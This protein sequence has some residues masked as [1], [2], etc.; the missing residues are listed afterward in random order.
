MWAPGELGRSESRG[1]SE[2]L[3]VGWVPR[4]DRADGQDGQAPP[5]PA[6]MQRGRVQTC[7]KWPEP[8]RAAQAV[9]ASPA[10]LL[11]HNLHFPGCLRGSEGVCIWGWRDKLWD[12]PWSP[13]PKAP[14]LSTQGPS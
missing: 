10:G 14:R 5:S 4:M 1:F 13:T 2:S 7:V 12:S 9:V 8:L 6:E 3:Q 11:W